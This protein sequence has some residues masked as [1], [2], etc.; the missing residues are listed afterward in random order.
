M[1][2]RLGEIVGT[3]SPM[4]TGSAAA[5]PFV[6]HLHDGRCARVG[7]V[8]AMS[9]LFC[10]ACDRIRI[11]ADGTLYPCLMDK[12]A[13]TLMPALRPTIDLVEIDRRLSLGMHAKALEHPASGDAVMTAVGG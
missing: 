13:G 6:A 5:R 2:Q 12:P 8:T 7:F 10:G 4:P 3:W 9:C 11:G 1:R